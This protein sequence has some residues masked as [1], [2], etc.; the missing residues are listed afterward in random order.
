MLQR[1]SSIL[2]IS[3]FFAFFCVAQNSDSE[4]LVAAML[5]HTQIQDD[6]HELCDKIG[7]RVTGTEANE[8]AI[9]WGVKKFKEAGVEVKKEA[10]QMPSL[11]DEKNCTAKIKGTAN[12]SPRVVSRAF[13]VGTPPDGL[14]AELIS[15]GYGTEEDFKKSGDKIKDKFILVTTDELVELGGLFKEYNDAHEIEGRALASQVKGVVYMSS[16]PK[17]LL[18]RHLAS[19][20]YNNT[21][22]IVVMARDD[23]S[24]CLR[25]LDKGGKLNINLSIELTTGG[26][27]T[28][29]N[30]IGEIKG[31][32]KPDEIVLIG[33]HLDSW[34][35]GTGAND[36]GCNVSLVIDI[37]RQMTLL[38]I[39]P[40]RTIRFAL[41]NG[42]EQ[43][44]CGSYAYTQQHEKELDKH[45]VI[46]SIDIGSGKITGFFT[47]H[48]PDLDAETKKALEAVA[49]LGPFENADVPIVGT[50]NY[51]FMMQ[52]VPNLVGK[53]EGANYCSDYHCESDTYD[54]VN[55][56]NL[57]INSAI[58]AVTMLHFANV[59]KVTLKRH[60]RNDVQKMI[61]ETKLDVPMKAFEYWQGWLDGT[62][63]R[64]P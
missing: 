4:K 32:E 7:G 2:F 36:N 9:E 30:V 61:D 38:G 45:I 39:K 52:G 8:K 35:M 25:I 47:G 12:F 24:R 14:E 49:S 63:G 57:K 26:S 42:E 19:R 22:P 11:W 58:A 21:L 31:N 10:F 60:N 27:Y 28:S 33:A 17:K 46:A 50:D 34:G 59:D 20:G 44:I 6:L 18:F 16:R 54:K 53:Q 3:F 43:C 23:A 40:K 64:K 51:D 37:A 5:G 41:W 62:R 56:Q 13:S 29:Y 48:R 1:S 15:V 55:L